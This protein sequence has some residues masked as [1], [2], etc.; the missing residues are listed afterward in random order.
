MSEKSTLHT[1]EIAA[2]LQATLKAA[3]PAY[4]FPREAP[5]AAGTRCGKLAIICPGLRQSASATNRTVQQTYR[6]VVSGR[7]LQHPATA[8]Q[9]EGLAA[10]LCDAIAADPYLGGTVW[11]AGVVRVT[12]GANGHLGLVVVARRSEVFPS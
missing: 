10:C 6:L 12:F 2:A 4:E 9:V 3:A 5:E 11:H 7:F 8:E 1:T